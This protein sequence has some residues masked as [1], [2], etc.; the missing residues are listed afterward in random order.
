MNGEFKT[1]TI[2]KEAILDLYDPIMDDKGNVIAFSLEGKMHRTK[3]DREIQAYVP[4]V[5]ASQKIDFM[6]GKARRQLRRR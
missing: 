5:K 6:K 2:D 3:T 1:I 4:F